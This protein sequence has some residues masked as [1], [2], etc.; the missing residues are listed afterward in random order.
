MEFVGKIWKDGKFWLVEVPVIDVCTQGHTR[1]EALMMIEDAI[2][3][4][5]RSYF[6]LD[7]IKDF[8]LEVI[9]Y[10]KNTIGIKA[11][12]NNI[13]LSFSLIRQREMSKSTVR[14][15]A[16]RLGSKSPNSYAQYERGKMR[17]TL[18]QYERLLEAVNPDGPPTLR[19]V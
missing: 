8:R 3:E 17:V 5:L 4:L 12:N 9:D 7:K 18:D 19:V 10:E 1:K 2:M 6:P 16:E 14:E 15:V 11:S 13:I